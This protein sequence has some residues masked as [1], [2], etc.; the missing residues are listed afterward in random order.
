VKCAVHV[1]A[2][3]H[4]ARAELDKA[5]MAAVAHDEPQIAAAIDIAFEATQIAIELTTQRAIGAVP[6]LNDHTAETVPTHLQS[7]PAAGE[8]P[9]TVR[10]MPLDHPPEEKR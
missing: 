3:L 8:E 7:V 4:F 5:R 1:V 2:T 9:K 10:E 6:V